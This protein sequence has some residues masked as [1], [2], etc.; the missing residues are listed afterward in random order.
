VL[1]AIECTIHDN[2]RFAVEAVGGATVRV[3]DSD[4]TG[5]VLGPWGVEYG[6]EVESERN[7][8]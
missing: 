5:N 8:D 7:I 6:A 1:A 3:E 2:G 4:L